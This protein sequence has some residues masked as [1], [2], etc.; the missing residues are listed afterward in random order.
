MHRNKLLSL[1][2]AHKPYDSHE[3]SMTQQVID[4]VNS[5]PDCFDNRHPIGH[6]TASAWII[7]IQ[8]QMTG[9]VHHR[10]LNKWLQTGGHSDGSSDTPQEA[11]REAQEE[12]GI[13]GLELHSEDIY[14]IDVHPVPADKK[15][16]LDNHLHY[17]IRFLITGN[18]SI[19]PVVSDESHEAKWV[20]VS[21]VHELNSEEGIIRMVKKTPKSLM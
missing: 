4:F 1:L 3:K 7:D 2:T 10:K 20:P 17:D 9:L 6:V 15:R 13:E 11:L 18:S 12:F 21:K 16:G 19:E 14:D 8:E 5:T